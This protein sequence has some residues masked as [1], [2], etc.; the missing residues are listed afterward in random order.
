MPTSSPSWRFLSTLN[1]ASPRSWVWGL[2]ISSR[3]SPTTELFVPVAHTL[4][5]FSVFA[6]GASR[7]S[8]AYRTPFYDAAGAQIA[9]VGLG[10]ARDAIDTFKGMATTKTPAIGT[11]TL[12]NLHT[13]HERV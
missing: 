8:R 11:T 10:I 1:S 12:A 4:P 3:Y 7:P 6:S 5:L 2:S 9:A 13:T